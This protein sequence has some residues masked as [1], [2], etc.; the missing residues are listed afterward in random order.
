MMAGYCCTAIIR[1]PAAI[2][3]YSS[4]RLNVSSDSATLSFVPFSH[5][6]L[7]IRS[8]VDT[9]PHRTLKP[10]SPPLP[11]PV[12]AACRAGSLPFPVCVP[13]LCEL[14]AP[15]CALL[16]DACASVQLQPMAPTH[17]SRRV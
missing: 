12:P 7:R 4:K 14:C 6:S 2:I 1:Y 5:L 16:T 10:G 13:V 3:R 8:L 17:W 9:V 11:P 15:R